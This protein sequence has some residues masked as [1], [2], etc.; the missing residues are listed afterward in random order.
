M[1]SIAAPLTAS[2]GQVIGGLVAFGTSMQ[3]SADGMADQRLE[4]VIVAFLV[5]RSV[6][7]QDQT[8]P[9][10]TAAGLQNIAVIRG[11]G[12]GLHGE[13]DVLV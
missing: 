9:V 10:R 3:L 12:G 1:S 5:M 13:N 11:A 4:G 7:E 8:L 2:N 6:I